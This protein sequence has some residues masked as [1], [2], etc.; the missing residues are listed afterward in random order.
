M[1][2]SI[3]INLLLLA[4]SLFT[5]CSNEDTPNPTI[6]PANDPDAIELGITAGVALT[7]SAINE[8][9]DDTNLKS[10]AVYA[11]GTG[12]SYDSDN[13][14]ALYTKNEGSWASG[15]DKIY[16]TNE[17]ATIY[18][19]HPAYAPD[20]NGVMKES[21]TAL[22]ITSNETFANSTINVS[23]FQGTTDDGNRKYPALSTL[24]NADKTWNTSDWTTTNANSAKIISA[25]GEVDYMWG[26]NSR[27]ESNQA[28][29]NNGKN[30]GP[31]AEVSL[32]MKHA[33]SMISFL[34]YNDGTYNN[35]GALTKIV[36]KN[37]ESKTDLTTGV[38]GENK[39][40]MKIG[41]GDIFNGSGGGTPKAATYTR[42]FTDASG[43]KIMKVV[44]NT[45]NQ[46]NR[47]AST[48]QAAKD[49]SAKFSILVLPTTTAKKANIEAV[50]TIDNVDYSVPLA[51]G[52]EETVSW[53][54]GT[55]NLYTVKLSGKE[56]SITNVTVA[57]WTAA[58]GGNLDVN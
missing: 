24:N 3:N 15:S 53:A 28:T 27:N 13:N 10:I 58:T 51:T 50:F 17:V 49:A 18:A 46:S 6:N 47:Y 21:G 41:S 2:H 12:T 19:Y 7:K 14:Y 35:T 45:N 32:K 8:G 40:T 22:T 9:T 5:A 1:K 42:T 25:P 55:N 57:A 20:A 23:V 38:V 52:G 48:E 34:I 29:A 31:G 39:P 33:L 44:A 11:N 26:V 4:T 16:L 56:L 43:Y 37:K 30:S 54:K 36:L